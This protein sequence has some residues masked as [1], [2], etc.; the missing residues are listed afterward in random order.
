MLPEGVHA[1]K[2]WVPAVE[3]CQ[4]AIQR[5]CCYHAWCCV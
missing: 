4:S 3:A 1:D 2:S 5:L